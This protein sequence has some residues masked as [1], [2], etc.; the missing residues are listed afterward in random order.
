MAGRPKGTEKIKSSVAQQV[1]DLALSLQWLGL[2][3]WC[4]FNPW[5]GA[6]L[7]A[8]E[9]EKEGVDKDGATGSL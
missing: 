5:P 8:A 7:H 2:L 3:L 9:S 4:E 6:F 1:K